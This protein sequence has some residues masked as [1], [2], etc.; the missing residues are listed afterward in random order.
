VGI[1]VFEG[2]G[3]GAIKKKGLYVLDKAYESKK[4]STSSLGTEEL[5]RTSIC[6]E[7]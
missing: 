7:I 4:P 6:L 5:S 3:R 2:E 1:G